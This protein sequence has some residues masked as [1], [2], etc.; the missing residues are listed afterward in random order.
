M[1]QADKAGN[2]GVCFFGHGPVGDLCTIPRGDT[3]NPLCVL[4]LIFKEGSVVV[5]AQ[6]SKE[7]GFYYSLNQ[8][9]PR[10][11]LSLHGHRQ[12]VTTKADGHSEFTAHSITAHLLLVVLPRLA[13][14][15]TI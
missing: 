15:S 8:I 4:G 1:E 13:T 7:R 3:I 10:P 9:R 6:A 2:E 11:A 14:L 5:P 12:A